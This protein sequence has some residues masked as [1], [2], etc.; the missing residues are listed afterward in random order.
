M[1]V[2]RFC[3][4]SKQKFTNGSVPLLPQDWKDALRSWVRLVVYKISLTWLDL[5]ILLLRLDSPHFFHIDEKISF[6]DSYNYLGYV[7]LPGGVNVFV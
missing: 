6:P 1:F 7:F 2:R 3:F 5:H 4:Y